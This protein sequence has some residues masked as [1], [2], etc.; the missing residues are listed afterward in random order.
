MAR[1]WVIAPY[2][3]T[4][5][6]IWEK[7]WEYDIAKG[8]IAIGWKELGNISS[9]DET[10]LR[11][12]I[13]NKYSDKKEGDKTS[14][15]NSMWRFWHEIKVGDFIVARKG[16]KRIAAIGDV[17]QPAF[18]NTGMGYDRV[19]RLTDNYYSNFIG[20]RWHD[21]PRDIEFDK[22]VFSIKTIYD[23]PEAKY[24]AL[25][26][27]DI[28]VE[29]ADE[30]I[31]EQSEFVLEKYLEEF[32]VSNFDRI[33]KGT[34]ALYKDPEGNVAQQYP[35]DIGPIDILAK[36]PETHSFVVI[37]LKKGRESDKVIGQTLRYMG[38]VSE[39][40]CTDNQK[41]KAIII[42]KEADSKLLLALKMT[43]NID[44]KFYSLD[45]KLIDK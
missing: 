43:N 6:N 31:K 22:P 34:L 41:V 33:F 45:F 38:W 25:L 28:P 21:S 9:C 37:E 40:L 19:G 13:E 29:L 44:L 5:T 39:N 14:T 12:L 11:D 26:N 17:T 8:V 3:S 42:C 7:V 18:Y 27:K 4:K 23:I 35:T 20:V 32:I 2:D 1:F 15:F 36:E 30:E 10:K 16:T 24:K